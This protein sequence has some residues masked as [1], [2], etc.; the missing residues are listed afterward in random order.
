MIIKT[1]GWIKQDTKVSGWF[2]TWCNGWIT[3]VD[4]NVFLAA[5]SFT[6]GNNY[7]FCLVIIQFLQVVGHPCFDVLDAGFNLWYDSLSIY[8]ITWLKWYIKLRIISI[9]VEIQIMIADDSGVVYMV[10]RIGP[11][12]DPCGTP[13]FSVTGSDVLDPIQTVWVLSWRYD[14]SHIRTSPLIPKE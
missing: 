13:Y 3:N 10:N 7:K 8:W 5:G 4:D 2:H 14:L 11:S 12:T 9:K 6:G 1:T